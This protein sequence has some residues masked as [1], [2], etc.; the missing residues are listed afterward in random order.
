ME[1]G[2]DYSLIKKDKKGKITADTV[3][4]GCCGWT[5]DF[6]KKDVLDLIE[7]LKE[8]ILAL[9]ELIRE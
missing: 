8:K 6:S 5:H 4:C 7:E 3:G 1:V 9:Q 2:F